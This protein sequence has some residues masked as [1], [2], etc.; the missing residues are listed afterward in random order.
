MQFRRM[1]IAPAAVMAAVLLAAGCGGA[2]G[3]SGGGPTA[4]GT[5]PGTGSDP[6]NTNVISI[7]DQAFSPG[8]IS[9]P[10]GTTVTWKWPT[11][12]D[13]GY[14]GYGGCVTHNVTFDDGSKI[15]SATQ[16]N[17]TFTRTFSAAGVFKYHCTIHGTGMSGQV[18]VK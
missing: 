12:N 11:C 7:A 6:A 3:A 14:G 18:T 13:T 16:D 15:A 4:P 9:V 17:G 1:K 10:V 2:G 8:S 5:S